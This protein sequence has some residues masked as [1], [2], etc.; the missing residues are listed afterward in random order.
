MTILNYSVGITIVVTRTDKQHNSKCLI[1]CCRTNTEEDGKKKFPLSPWA[2]LCLCRSSDQWWRGWWFFRNHPWDS[3]SHRGSA[4][5]PPLHTP[6][7]SLWFA[8]LNVGDI[9]VTHMHTEHT[10][11]PQSG[12]YIPAPTKLP[13]A[14]VYW[15][16]HFINRGE[17]VCLSPWNVWASFC[18]TWSHSCSSFM[19]SV[20][21]SI[22]ITQVAELLWWGSESNA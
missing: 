21:L 20:A 1:R 14:S 16:A 7:L 19:Q 18:V 6:P 10:V 13:H 9:T 5:S 17:H 8:V 12:L 11:R 3:Q 4:L 15:T 22:S 2:A